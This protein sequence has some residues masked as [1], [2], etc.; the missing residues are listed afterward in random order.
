MLSKLFKSKKTQTKGW[1]L[2][3]DSDEHR[4]IFNIICGNK[5]LLVRIKK[6]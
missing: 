4:N 2:T 5:E 3:P 6:D 1:E